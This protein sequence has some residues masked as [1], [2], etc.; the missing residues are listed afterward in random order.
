VTQKATGVAISPVAAKTRSPATPPAPAPR[1]FFC[2]NSAATPAAGF[3]TR[4]KA[5]CQRARD[6]AIAAVADLDECRLT[7]MAYCFTAGGTERCAPTAAGCADR[8][9]AVGAATPCDERH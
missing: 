5:D 4:E 9:L 8:A 3:C 7:E 1:G 2:S 6:A